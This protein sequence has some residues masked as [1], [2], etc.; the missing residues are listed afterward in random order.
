MP[1]AGE[2][3]LDPLSEAL[4]LARHSI[5]DGGG[6][7][8]AVVTRGGVIVGRGH[9]RVVLD[10]DPSAH[11][12]I[13]AIRDAARRLGTHDLSEC[14]LYASCEPCPM[15][16]GAI[17]WAR[18]ARLHYAASQHDAAAAGFDDCAFHA[19]SSKPPEQRRPPREQ[20]RADEG[21]AVFELWRAKADRQ[22]Y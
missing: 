1:T 19:E 21:R 7:F 15:C 9:N 18:I 14:E 17:L 4:A 11:A 13:V 3:P 10:R 2:K 8:G 20:R 12:E 6:P 22:A 16:A 5:A